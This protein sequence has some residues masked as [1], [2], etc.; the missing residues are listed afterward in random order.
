[1]ITK[2]GVGV[3]SRRQE[4][5]FLTSSVLSWIRADKK[6]PP[7]PHHIEITETVG[8]PYGL[9]VFSVACGSDTSRLSGVLGKGE[10]N[11]LRRKKVVFRWKRSAGQLLS[12]S[13]RDKLKFVLLVDSILTCIRGVSR[14]YLKAGEESA[15]CFLLIQWGCR[16]PL[17]P[18]AQRVACQNAM[19]GLTVEISPVRRVNRIRWILAINICNAIAITLRRNL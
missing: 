1:M 3:S 9:F 13:F 10:S 8:K 19:S 6:T 7:L 16:S 2:I 15:D 4:V 18:R 11:M 14:L 17:N 12:T 5:P